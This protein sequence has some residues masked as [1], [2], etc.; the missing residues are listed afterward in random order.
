M[1]ALR[2]FRWAIAIGL[3][4]VADVLAFYAVA[5]TGLEE[6]C[7]NGIARWSCEPVI[8]DAAPPIFWL[9]LLALVTV[10]GWRLTR[11]WWRGP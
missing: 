10:A 7:D 1:R 4:A 11:W 3:I 9:L 5:V 8:R 6:N 2:R